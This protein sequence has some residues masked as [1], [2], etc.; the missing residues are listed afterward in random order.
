MA[1]FSAYNDDYVTIMV[2]AKSP[3]DAR[4]KVQDIIGSI[5]LEM[6]LDFFEDDISDSYMTDGETT[7]EDW[8]KDK[9][10]DFNADCTDKMLIIDFVD[11]Q[12]YDL[13]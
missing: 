10:I 4:K 1:I 9:G 3:K 7:V 13:K 5:G 11:L 12:I 6:D 2:R 8:L